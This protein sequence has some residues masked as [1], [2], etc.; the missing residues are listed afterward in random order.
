M[1]NW[2][3]CHGFPDY[4]VSTLGSIRSKER[5]RP[6]RG[7][8]EITIKPKVLSP[9]TDRD[10]YRRI[11]IR[12]NGIRSYHK[13]SRLTALTFIPNPENKPQV[14]HKNG[15]RNDDRLENLEWCTCSENSIHR[16]YVLGSK[17][18]MIPAKQRGDHPSAK[19]IIQLDMNGNFVKKFECINDAADEGFTKSKL[20]RALNGHQSQHGGYKW[21][22]S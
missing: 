12:L 5:K 19:P 16:I 7:K 1:E 20:S 2:L 11:G 13:L 17:N 4:E 15:I 10:G 22:F 21:V 6:C 3:T 9:V 8:K 14:N 18:Y